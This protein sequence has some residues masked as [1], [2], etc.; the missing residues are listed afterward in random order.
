MKTYTGDR[1]IDIRGRELELAERVKV[2]PW[3]GWLACP[4]QGD[5]VQREHS[6]TVLDTEI[7]A[8]VEDGQYVLR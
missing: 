8:V 6:A 1:V 4:V 7:T 3:R 2:G 5:T